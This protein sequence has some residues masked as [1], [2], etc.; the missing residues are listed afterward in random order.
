MRRKNLERKK[1]NTLT[2]GE[3]QHL[4]IGWTLDGDQGFSSEE[5]LREAYF[6]HRDYLMSLI[7]IEFEYG[8]R[9][10]AWWQFENLPEKKRIVK[11]YQST[12]YGA[13]GDPALPIEECD[14]SYLLRNNLLLPGE[15][16]EY[17]KHIEE[18]RGKMGREQF[19]NYFEALYGEKIHDSGHA[20]KSAVR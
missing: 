2:E 14:F 11:M 15:E 6:K 17:R 5:E 12:A 16:E 19:D 18:M 7:G 3:L 1:T 20:V 8:K 9:P 4:L 10:F 13:E